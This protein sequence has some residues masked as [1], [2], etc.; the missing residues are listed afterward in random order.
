MEYAKT[1]LLTFEPCALQ[2]NTLNFELQR[3]ITEELYELFKPF[4]YI[5]TALGN[6]RL[7]EVYVIGL[8]RSMHL[9][10]AGKIGAYTLKV[11]ILNKNAGHC[12]GIKAVSD[13]IKCQITK[14]QM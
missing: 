6:P 13:K 4:G 14:Y 8:D 3:P 7:G 11:S 1:S 9:K 2:E 10:L 12:S 5:N